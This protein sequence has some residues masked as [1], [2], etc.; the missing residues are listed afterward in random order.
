[1]SEP[2]TMTAEQEAFDR[3]LHLGHDDACAGE[4]LNA[5]ERGHDEIDA[6]RADLAALEK[7]TQRL[8]DE[9]QKLRVKL[10][11][12]NSNPYHEMGS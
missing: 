5:M 3:S 1:M 9:N 12:A 6:L 4:L 2:L 8:R 10:S 11:W 7:D